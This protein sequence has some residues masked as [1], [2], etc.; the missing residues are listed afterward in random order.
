MITLKKASKTLGIDLFKSESK[1]YSFE[2]ES[3]L[4]AS[5][6]ANQYKNLYSV[7]CLVL[8]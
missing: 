2:V 6:Q 7:I 5:L 3:S 4:E 1:K 8:R